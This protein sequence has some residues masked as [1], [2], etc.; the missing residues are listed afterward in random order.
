MTLCQGLQLKT[1]EEKERAD[2][3][4]EIY[5]KSSSLIRFQNFL[6]FP[7][8]PSESDTAYFMCEQKRRKRKICIQLNEFVVVSLNGSVIS[9]FPLERS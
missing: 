3:E 5:K 1:R 4:G 2:S 9:D 7:H 8:S 6:L